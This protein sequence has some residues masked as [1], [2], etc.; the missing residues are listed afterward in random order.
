MSFTLEYEKGKQMGF[1]C[2][3]IYD[4]KAFTAAAKAARKTVG[5]SFNRITHAGAC[6][7]CIMVLMGVLIPIWFAHKEGESMPAAILLVAVPVAAAL[8]LAIILLMAFE[9]SLN[10]R[11]ANKQMQPGMERVITVFAEENLTVTMGNE[12]QE[13][14]YNDIH[15]L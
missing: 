3:T 10:G 11:R 8:V 4:E 5:K 15:R 9:D 13:F 14:Q 6:V 1:I 12:K 7:F 2:E